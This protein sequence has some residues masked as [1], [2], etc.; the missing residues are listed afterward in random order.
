MFPGCHELE[1]KVEKAF[2]GFR[3]CVLQ[4]HFCPA[5]GAR[6]LVAINMK[7][8][9][10]AFGTKEVTYK[11]RVSCD[12]LKASKPAAICLPQCVTVRAVT[13]SM[14]MTHWNLPSLIVLSGFGTRTCWGTSVA[15][16]KS[17]GGAAT[18]VD[19]VNRRSTSTSSLNGSS[20]A[21][22]SSGLLDLAGRGAGCVKEARRFRKE[23]DVLDSPAVAECC[24][25]GAGM[26]S[27]AGASRSI[28]T[29]SS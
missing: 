25:G 7:C 28:E 9:V 23:L 16:D 6:L 24:R 5:H 19:P 1:L 10:Q 14:Q 15:F 27:E 12:C 13:S 29:A 8:R 2:G 18:P 11:Y 21:L 4:I 22:V 20:S 17:I 26:G 3:F